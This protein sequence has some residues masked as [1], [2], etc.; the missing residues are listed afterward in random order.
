MQVTVDKQLCSNKHRWLT[1]YRSDFFHA[2]SADGNLAS[3][4]GRDVENLL[5]TGYVGGKGRYDDALL[6]V[7]KELFQTCPDRLLRRG[8]TGALDVGR[9]AHQ[10][11]YTFL[12]QFS[13]ACQINHLARCRREVYLEVAG[14][15]DGA[16]RGADGEGNRVGNR[17]V[18][19]DKL[20]RK[21]AQL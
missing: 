14:V 13:K 18:G 1:G 6:T 9:V 3:I 19:V 10:R 20:N 7:L 5:E 16:Q 11:Q 2:A 4:L 12:P 15:D 21:A 8:V 17:V